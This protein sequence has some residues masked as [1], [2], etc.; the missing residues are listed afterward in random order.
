MDRI[1]EIISEVESIAKQNE[2]SQ[3]IMEL[4][5]NLAQLSVSYGYIEGIKVGKN[6]VLQA[7][8]KALGTPHTPSKQLTKY[9]VME[10][11]LTEQVFDYV[12]EATGSE[13]IIER[14]DI[15]ADILGNIH[16]SLSVNE[17]EY[18]DKVREYQKGC[19]EDARIDR[20]RGK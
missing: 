2:G 4:V 20:A 3:D 6:L 18:L 15:L 1:R 7:A 9:E 14:M 5:G 19:A 11:D 12:N 10:K 8:E 13:A 16:F 17:C